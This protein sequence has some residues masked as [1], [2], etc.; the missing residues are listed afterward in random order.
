MQILKSQILL[1][2][3]V[4]KIFLIIRKLEKFTHAIREKILNLS[5]R[6]NQT[7]K[8]ATLLT[9]SIDVGVILNFFFQLIFS[10]IAKSNNK[11]LIYCIAIFFYN[12][13]AAIFQTAWNYGYLSFVCSCCN[14]THTHTHIMSPLILSFVY[15]HSSLTTHIF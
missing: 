14:G 10:F 11:N 13:P 1:S 5:Q 8:H 6:L 3:S 4:E 7:W 15:S 9:L 2:L 12:W